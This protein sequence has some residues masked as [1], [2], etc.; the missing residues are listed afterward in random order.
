[1]GKKRVINLIKNKLSTEQNDVIESLKEEIKTKDI[2]IE[3]LKQALSEE[4]EKKEVKPTKRNK[5]VQNDR[6]QFNN[7]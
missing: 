2:A 4:N 7:S 5:K 6:L 1:M 3:N